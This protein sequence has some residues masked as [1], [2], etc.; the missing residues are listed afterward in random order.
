[1]AKK[2]TTLKLTRE[3]SLLLRNCN[4]FIERFMKAKLAVEV[5]K[6][7]TK[8]AVQIIASS[9]TSSVATAK[10]DYFADAMGVSELLVLV[11]AG[12]IQE[13]SIF[14]DSIFRKVVLHYLETDMCDALPSQ[15]FNLNKIKATSFYDMRVSISQAAMESFSFENYDDKIKMLRSIFGIKSS[16]LEEKD[17]IKLEAMNAK[18][19]KHV[20]I[21]NVFQHNRGIIRER[22]LTAIGQKYFELLDD[23]GNKRQYKKD[24]EMILSKPEIENLNELIKKYS[25]KFEVLP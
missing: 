5:G 10:Q 12:F 13:W 18:V 7:S 15:K 6:A 14:L 25:E 1:M 8:A 4:K 17:K 24:D 23:D 22:D 16:Q 21:R 9:D 3:R 19:K 11:H 2:T 20:E